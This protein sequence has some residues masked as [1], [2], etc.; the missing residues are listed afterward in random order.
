M[1]VHTYTLY[2]YAGIDIAYKFKMPLPIK[3]VQYSA[4]NGQ[5]TK[6]VLT[7]DSP[8]YSLLPNTHTHTHTHTHIE[9]ASIVYSLAQQ[10][11]KVET[12]GPNYK[13]LI[14]ASDYLGA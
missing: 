4:S 1:Y 5:L 11:N 2:Y 9:G 7:R 8:L 3:G 13:L 10:I 6:P 12:I 14:T